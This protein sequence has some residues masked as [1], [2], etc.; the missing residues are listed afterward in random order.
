MMMMMMMMM[1]NFD[2]IQCTS[3]NSSSSMVVSLWYNVYWP[4]QLSYS[5]IVQCRDACPFGFNSHCIHG[6]TFA[7]QIHYTVYT[8][9]CIS[10]DVY[11]DLS[12]IQCTH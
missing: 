11:L 1:M 7:C 10:T 3:S 9:K 6:P 5:T 8:R 12:R 2:V 4:A